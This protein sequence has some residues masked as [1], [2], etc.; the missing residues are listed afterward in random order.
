M[1]ISGSDWL[2]VPTLYKAYFSGL[3]FRNIPTI[4]IRPY[5][6]GTNVPSIN[7]F[8]LH[9]HWSTRNFTIQI[10]PAMYIL[11][12]SYMDILIL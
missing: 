12:Q 5:I 2:E 4:H 7:R 6:Y 11:G 3:N 10:I 1:G 9:D 8:L